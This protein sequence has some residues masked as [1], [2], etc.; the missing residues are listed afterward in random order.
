VS[1]HASRVLRIAERGARGERHARVLSWRRRGGS[2]RF[3]LSSSACLTVA[4]VRARQTPHRQQTTRRPRY[5]R[6]RPWL[7]LLRCRMTARL[8]LRV[9]TRRKGA[10]GRARGERPEAQQRHGDGVLRADCVGCRARACVPS[11]AL[12]GFERSD[13]GTH[14]AQALDAATRALDGAND[15][16]TA[17]PQRARVPSP[18][19]LPTGARLRVATVLQMRH[20]CPAALTH[21]GRPSPG[22]RRDGV[23]VYDAPPS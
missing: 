8:P 15:E 11:T 16:A 3:A 14:T 9:R 23:H 2:K 6:V 13:A 4:C 18:A 7:L 20:L 1:V 5:V 19:T 21:T 17:V 10:C 22:E 12:S